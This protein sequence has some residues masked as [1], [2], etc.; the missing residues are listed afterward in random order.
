[1]CR[2]CHKA[3]HNISDGSVASIVCMLGHMM[4]FDR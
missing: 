4:R 1:L 3:D 2:S